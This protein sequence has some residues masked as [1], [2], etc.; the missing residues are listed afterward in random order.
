MTAEAGLQFGKSNIHKDAV[1]HT[2][3]DE[4]VQG[5]PASGQRFRR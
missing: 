2:T 4:E 5:A 1:I 3:G